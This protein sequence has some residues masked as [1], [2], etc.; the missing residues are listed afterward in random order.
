MAARIHLAVVAFVAIVLPAANITLAAE[1]WNQFLGPNRNGIAP[2]ATGLIDTWPADGP[3]EV[4]RVSAG[5]GMSGLAISGGKLC[6]LV[7]K[8]KQQ[9]LVALDPQTGKQLWET[10]LAPEYKNAQGD[11]PR[12]TPTISGDRVFAHTGQGVLACVNRTNGS[13]VWSHNT[14]GETKGKVAEYG[15]SCSPLIVGDLVIV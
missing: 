2:S 8:D 12:A 6:T 11:G 14:I 10:A 9:W 4:W 1:D 7:Q 3:R 5:V 13:L 15:M